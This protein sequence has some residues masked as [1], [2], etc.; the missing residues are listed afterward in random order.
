[1]NTKITDDFIAEFNEWK[2][3]FQKKGI[4]KLKEVFVSFWESNPGVK[5]IV[6]TQYAPYYNDGDPCTF[7][8]NS[9]TFSNATEEDDID[10]LHYGE[11]NGHYEYV[12]AFDPLDPYSKPPTFPGVDAE[13]MIS[14]SKFITSEAMKSILEN[15]LGSNH[16]I[17]VTRKGIKCEDYSSSHD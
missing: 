14:L 8:V 15:V 3:F 13:S 16:R 9:P 10:N 6:W 2:A 5:V 12:W 1:M 11:Y 4:E 7:S 17:I